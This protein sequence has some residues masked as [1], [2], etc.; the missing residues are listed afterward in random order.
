MSSNDDASASDNDA[1][2]VDIFDQDYLCKRFPKFLT[3]RPLIEA[4]ARRF[5][6]W[7]MPV[8]DQNRA[9]MFK[10]V[11]IFLGMCSGGTD[12][13][14]TL[15]VDYLN[16]RRRTG[17]K[18]EVVQKLKNDRLEMLQKHIKATLTACSKTVNDRETDLVQSALTKILHGAVPKAELRD[19]S[20][21]SSVDSLGLVVF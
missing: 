14:S 8:S 19:F 3:L 1:S 2:A 9:K 20:S 10:I 12:E 21:P 7:R 18:A 17:R 11:E 13:I 15:L 6:N 4:L 5:K 16:T